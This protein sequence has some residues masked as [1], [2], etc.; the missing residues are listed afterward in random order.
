ML[1]IIERVLFR[2]DFLFAALAGFALLYMMLITVAD[3]FG[4]SLGLLTI[5]SGVEQ[6][7][8]L[9]VAIGFLG[10]ARCLRIRGNIVVDF[11]THH[12]PHRVNEIIDAFWLVVMA[13]VLFLLAV[14]VMREGIGLDASGQRSELLGL[15]P[16]LDHTVATVGMTA[17][18]LVA[19]VVA[20]RDLVGGPR[21][22]SE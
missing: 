9:M 12:L 8:L 6:T 16:L 7:E 15:S 17:G 18:A 4:R 1:P 22:T 13:V 14:L 2:L 3:I 5:D 19:L 10:L 11:A 20:W 21:P